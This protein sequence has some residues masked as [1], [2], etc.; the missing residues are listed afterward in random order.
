V[1]KIFLFILLAANLV[2]AQLSKKHWIPPLH[3]RE[4]Y[5]VGDHYVY[6]ST[7][8]PTPFQVVITNGAG[9]PIPGSPF[10][11]SQGN[12]VRVTIG[13]QQPSVAFLSQLNLSTVQSDKGLILEGSKEFYASFR[14]R[15]QN[16]AEI[17]VSKGTSGIGTSFRIGGLPQNQDGPARNFVTSFM[18]TEDNTMVT[19]SDYDSGVEF[20]TSGLNNTAD[21]QT[22][23]LDQG[24][25]VVL[26]GYTNIPAN[27]SGFIGA[28][29]TATKPIA[30]NCGN[31]LAGMSS[32]NEGQDFTLDQ[33]VPMEQVGSEYIVVKGNGSDNVEH[34]LVIGTQNGTDIFVN[35]SAA[36]IATINA[37][38]FF[39]LPASLYQGASSKNMYITTSQPVYLYQIIGGAQSDAT[40]G[41]NFIPPLSCYFQK[42]V[43]LIPGVDEIGGTFYDGNLIIVTY[44]GST[45]KLN[46]TV[47]NDIPEPVLGNPTWCTYR[48]FGVGGNAKIESTG[49]LAVG[50]FGSSN[51]AGFAGYYSGFGSEPKDTNVA[52][53]SDRSTDLFNLIDGNPDPGGSWTPALASGT[54]VFDPAVDLPGIYVYNFTGLC[55]IVDVTVTVSIQQAL[56]P[57]V[58]T[59]KSVCYNSPSFDLFPLLG[60]NADLG[61]TWSPELNS[62][63]SMFNPAVDTSGVY[64]YTIESNDVCERVSATVTVTVDPLPVIAPISSF[65]ACDDA[66]DGDDTNGIVLFNLTDKTSEILNNQTDIAVTYHLL[67]SEAET[68][69]NPITTVY[70]GSR[71]IYARLENTNT[72]CYAV[73]SFDLVV[74]PLPSATGITFKQCDDNQDG[75]TSFNLTQANA[76]ISSQNNLTFTYFDNQANALAGTNSIPDPTQFISASRRIWVTVENPLGCSRIIPVDLVVSATQIPPTFLK[77]LYACDDYIDAND[78]EN[79]GY[80]YFDLNEATADILG[81]FPSPLTLT[82]TYYE[83]ET[84]ALTEQ[85]AIPLSQPYRNTTPN[86]QDIYVRV[87][88]NLNNDCEG[89]GPNL[90]LIVNT[91]P[92]VD[93]GNDFPL[94]LNPA[95]G[96]GSQFIDATPANAGNFTYHWTPA[97]PTVDAFGN[98]SPVYE[99]TQ[100]GTYQVTVTDHSTTLNCSNSDSVTVGVSSQPLTVTV[101]LI[102][103][104]FSSGLASI[105]V[106]AMGGYG[107]YEYS[108]DGSN[109]Q[110]ENTFSGLTN[111]SYV[112]LV[113]DVEQCGITP[114]EPFYTISYQNFFTPNGDGQNDSWKISNLPDSYQAKIY[115]FDRYGKLLKQISPDGEGWDGTFNGKP[116][117]ATDYW[118]KVEYLE[119]GAQKEFLNHFSLKR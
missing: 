113:R 46:G 56:N 101:N 55:E 107:V 65:N 96:L 21:T 116:L 28:L 58:S 105:E 31:A 108:L 97:N 36:P 93:L 64:T 69:T 83:N 114:S 72:Q 48:L 43:D 91:I 68:A 39:M 82:V 92:K 25:S 41:L 112:V 67:A 85:N 73:T 17:L 63:S 5:I 49:P 115:I 61:G 24:Q 103:P 100:S 80:G 44:T 27:L 118:F 11:V 42:T 110:S 30:V 40:S 16:H 29:I 90:K 19:V 8:E 57:G 102:T 37:G 94:C 54:G 4:D 77:E 98:E 109:W 2:N 18:A 52:V 75:I 9:I 38:D 99:I 45:V 50:V 74:Q 35:G 23:I 84:D 111:G 86:L 51:A 89:L 26:S 59:T 1:R 66:I 71:I 47:I 76:V 79:D 22:F 13:Y 10:T 104:L 88:S 60:T 95:T 14:M 78:P 53:C 117:P 7:P 3:S 15:S 12:P 34:P 20:A 62:G 87:D 119:N 106:I 70:S 33:I 81:L 32:P 6:L